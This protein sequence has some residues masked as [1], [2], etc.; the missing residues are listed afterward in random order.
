M[1]DGQ[2]EI[3]SQYTTG[4]SRYI[5]FLLAAAGA[6]IGLSVNLTRDAE[7]AYSQ[8]PLAGA[9][10]CWA[11]SFYSGCKN[12]RH[13]LALLS[14]NRALLAQRKTQ[15][16]MR[17]ILSERID[18]SV[19][20][21]AHQFRFLIA[22]AV[23]FMAWHVWGMVERSLPSNVPAATSQSQASSLSNAKGQQRVRAIPRRCA[24]ARDSHGSA[25]G[26]I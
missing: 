26:R 1:S 20:W 10:A 19:K 14:A 9:V 12:R 16:E 13:V 21:E 23:F 6:G 11:Y 5:Y 4:E 22:G 7:L 18:Q 17:I 15:A 25:E 24:A 3:F 2:L 8:L